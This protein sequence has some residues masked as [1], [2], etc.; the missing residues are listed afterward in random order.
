MLS[1][2]DWLQSPEPVRLPFLAPLLGYALLAGCRSREGDPACGITALAGATVLLDQFREPGQTMSEAPTGPPSI[3]PV[4]VA[5]GP[6]FRGRVGL[7][8]AGWAITVEGDLLPTAGVPGFGVLVVGA[9]GVARGVMVFSGRPVRGAPIIGRVLVGALDVPLLG[10][11][12]EVGGLEDPA[13]PFFPDSL[14]RP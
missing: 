3:I 7:D 10:L 5:A 6:A 8:E 1:T 4:R 13:C 2:P 9:D 11:Q 14:R 12:T